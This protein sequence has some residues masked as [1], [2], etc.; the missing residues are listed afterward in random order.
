MM[1][2]N[3]NENDKNFTRFHGDF[4]K[5]ITLKLF[6]RNHLNTFRTHYFSVHHRSEVSYRLT[7]NTL[8]ECIY[9][10]KKSRAVFLMCHYSCDALKFDTFHIQVTCRLY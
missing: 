4:M 1:K 5:L 3:H 8:N 2:I 9:K 6:Q 7:L 10:I